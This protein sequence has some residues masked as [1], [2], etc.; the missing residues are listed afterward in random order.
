MPAPI[1]LRRYAC[2]HVTVGYAQRTCCYWLLLLLALA[3]ARL[4]RMAPCRVA[5]TSAS[6]TGLLRPP[7]SRRQRRQS[8]PRRQNC[9]AT[10]CVGDGLY[11]GI[12][13]MCIVVA[14]KTQDTPLT[15]LVGILLQSRLHDIACSTSPGNGVR[16]HGV[17][18]VIR[19]Q[20]REGRYQASKSE[21]RHK[22]SKTDIKD[23][24]LNAYIKHSLRACLFRTVQVR[25]RIAQQD[26]GIRARVCACH[27]TRA[28][29]RFGSDA[30]A[31][32][33]T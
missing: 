25:A 10:R 30:F 27:L 26:A 22:T 4:N 32:G 11:A 19:H 33:Y 2:A 23:A 15:P 13:C 18:A 20:R 14:P 16:Q 9:N 28:L 21:D 31:R 29:L 8:A 17:G 12:Q 5:G 3:A 24:R 7:S 6:E 1:C